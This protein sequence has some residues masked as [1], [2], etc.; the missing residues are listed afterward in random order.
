MALFAFIGSSV[1]SVLVSVLLLIIGICNCGPDSVL[2]GAITAEMGN[3]DGLNAGAG[4][5]SF[6]NGLASTGGILEGPI[7]GIL[8][9]Y[10]GWSTVLLAIVTS[11]LVAGLALVRA[12]KITKLTKKPAQKSD[13]LS[14]A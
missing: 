9:S 5:T 12:D 3:V 2:I 7:L 8:V 10:F 14:K 6:V 1:G 13:P 4:V 11:T